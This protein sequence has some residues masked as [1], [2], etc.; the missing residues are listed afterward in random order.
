MDT[1]ASLSAVDVLFFG[2]H[3]DDV[4]LFA[5][6]LAATL[7]AQGHHVGICDMT[8]GEMG[9]LGSPELRQMESEAAGQV[10]GV[11]WRK[12]LGLPDAGLQTLVSGVSRES[13]VSPIVELLRAT[14]PFLVVAPYWED[15][16]PDHGAT[17][18]LI[19]ESL[20]LANARK[21]CPHLG[22]HHEVAQVLYYPTRTEISPSLVVDVSDVYDKKR[23]AILCYSSQ[24]SPN[25]TN[26]KGPQPLVGS[27][28]SLSS[29]EARDAYC[30]GLIGTPFGEAYLTKNAIPM[31]DPLKFFREAR[32]ATPLFYL[33]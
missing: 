31:H 3:P 4:E 13:V 8:R 7:S 22:S 23:Q 18:R 30:G 17:S 27:P 2:P 16:H 19:V 28:L 32:R 29:L 5:G 1:Q 10:L 6:G 21:F 20:F 25:R 15:R 12:N 26:F 14:K 9:S 11:L 33:R 24:V